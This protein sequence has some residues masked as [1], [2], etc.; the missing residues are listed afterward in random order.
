MDLDA[1][2]GAHQGEW[3]RL[4]SLTKQRRLTSAES[5]ELL[6]LYERVGT[7]LSYLRTNAPDPS[8]LQYLSTILARARSRAMG[9]RTASWASVAQFFVRD[10]PA[11]LYRMRRWWI[12]V[13]VVNVLVGFA[14]G[15]WAQAYPGVQTQL[16]SPQEIQQ[17]VESDFENYY[18]ENAAADFAGKVWT[19]N[20]WVA[21][22][23]IAG[24]VLGLPVLYMLWVNMFNVGII[25]GIMA[26]HGRLDLFFGL[27]LPHGLL[28]L[29]AVF[30]AAGVGLRLFWS[31]V[32]PGPVPRGARL[33][34]EARSAMTVVLGLV[35]VLFV[36]G[37]VEAFVTPSGLPT[38]AR[39]GIGVVVWLAFIVY[40]FTLGRVAH[41]EG[42]TGD[43]AEG[44]RE[45]ALPVVG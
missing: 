26:T 8:V 28:E 38:W 42:V 1:Y 43:L 15:W 25:G 32:E 30:V 17:L 16:I 33:A 36:S 35:V 7:H 27:I 4:A 2:V 24:G 10:F 22:V 20:A 9:T 34:Q 19:N 40:V 18:S 21:A 29:T 14:I 39:I 3:A 44:D 11:V 23:C 6:D 45:A 5:D 12:S 31:W 13:L 37:V 41:R